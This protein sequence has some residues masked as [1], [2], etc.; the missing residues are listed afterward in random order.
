LE[1]VYVN[2]AGFGCGHGDVI[3]TILYIL[4]LYIG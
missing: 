2:A 4:F 1:K 3:Y